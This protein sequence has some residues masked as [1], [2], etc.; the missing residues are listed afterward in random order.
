M[1][2]ITVARKRRITTGK[3]EFEEIMAS[4]KTQSSD[5]ANIENEAKAINEQLEQFLQQQETKIRGE[6]K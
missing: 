5:I 4:A 2:E 1:Q 6:K 3:Y